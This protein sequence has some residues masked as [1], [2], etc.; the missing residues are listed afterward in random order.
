MSVSKLTTEKK[1]M[2]AIQTH[3]CLPY[4]LHAACERILKTP[5][6]SAYTRHTSR[7]LIIYVTL[8]PILL[9]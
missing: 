9:W 8:S 5:L 4:Y 1:R 7:F 3:A 2:L 6:P